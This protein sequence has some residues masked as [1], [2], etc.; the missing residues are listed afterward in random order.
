MWALRQVAALWFILAVGLQVGAAQADPF[1]DLSLNCDQLEINAETGDTWQ[2]CSNDFIT[3]ETLQIC[4]EKPWESL[5]Y[6]GNK[7]I[8]DLLSSPIELPN[9]IVI[10]GLILPRNDYF[11][12]GVEQNV[13]YAGDDGVCQVSNLQADNAT[14]PTAGF[15]CVMYGAQRDDRCQFGYNNILTVYF[16]NWEDHFYEQYRGLLLTYI[17]DPS[18]YQPLR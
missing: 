15:H 11:P 2:V 7:F 13:F 18:W 4:V 8:F 3:I 10:S 9:Q 17:V 12:D 16:S 14:T 6:T 1:N 5:T